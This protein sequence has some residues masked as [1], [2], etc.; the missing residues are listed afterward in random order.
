[1]VIYISASFNENCLQLPVYS[2]EIFELVK[3]STMYMIV[4]YG[5]ERIFQDDISTASEQ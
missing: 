5:D 4:I 2:A 1:M 3:Y